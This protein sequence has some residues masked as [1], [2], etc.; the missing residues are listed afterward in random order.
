MYEASPPWS[1]QG[2]RKEKIAF[3]PLMSSGVETSHEQ[4][5]PHHLE[6]YVRGLKN[7]ETCL[8]YVFVIYVFS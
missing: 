5:L 3:L 1:K 4:I 7:L 8:D 2:K 6:L